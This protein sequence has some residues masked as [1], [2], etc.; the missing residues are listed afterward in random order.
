MLALVAFR[1]MI[2]RLVLLTP[3]RDILR[4]FFQYLLLRTSI[5]YC[6]AIMCTFKKAFFVCKLVNINSKGE[7]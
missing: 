5:H 7:R 1:L 2:I 4:S 6:D 3:L